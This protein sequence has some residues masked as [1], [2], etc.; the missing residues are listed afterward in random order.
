MI[1]PFASSGQV[2]LGIPKS[3]ILS[4]LSETK[5]TKS[6]LIGI[7]AQIVKIPV[8]SAQGFLLQKSWNL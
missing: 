3:R 1:L 6:L 4:V 2:L 7:Y 5:R 8:L